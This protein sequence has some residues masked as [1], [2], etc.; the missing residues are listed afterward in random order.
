MT[1]G[2]SSASGPSPVRVPEGDLERMELKPL[3]DESLRRAA[4]WLS[5]KE[6]YQWLHFGAGRQTLDAITLRV[7]DQRDLHLLRVFTPDDHDEAI[8]LVALSD[9]DPRFGTASVWYL[10]GEKEHARRGHTTRAVELLLDAGFDQLGLESVHAWTVEA[11]EPSQKL[12]CRLG[13]RLSGRHRRC[14]LIDGVAYDR[15][16]FDLLVEEHE[17]RRSER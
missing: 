5:R 1:R 11:N 16:L 4:D 8:G 2:E 12:L 14:H 10:L 15:L 7:M 3:D 17:E 6:N 9:I 13:F